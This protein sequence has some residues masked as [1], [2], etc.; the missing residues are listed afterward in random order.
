M[1]H[2]NRLVRSDLIKKT[3]KIVDNQCC[4]FSKFQN[5]DKSGKNQ[6]MMKL[7]L[8]QGQ[9][10]AQDALNILADMIRVKIRYHEAKIKAGAME[11]DI[12]KRG[13]RISEL[14][15]ALHQLR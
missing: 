12:H 3:Y 8:I 2:L 1:K 7:R 10:T 14:Q 6:M 11:E 5:P 9:F 4:C 13:R 15:D